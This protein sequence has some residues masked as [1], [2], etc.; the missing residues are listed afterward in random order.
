MSPARFFHLLVALAAL[1]GIVLS[2]A[3]GP[4]VPT[5][6][7]LRT[8]RFFSFFTISTNALVAWAAIGRALPPGRHWRAL[9]TRPSMRTAIA[10][11]ILVV[12][13]I[14]HLLLSDMVRP[15]LSG[16]LGNMLVH[17][18]APAGWLLCWFAFGP[19]GGIDARAPLRWM[20]YP[21]LYG[22]WTLAHGALLG[23]YPYPFMNVAS[24]GYPAVLRTMA[25]MALLFLAIAYALRWVDGR[26]A[27]R[28]A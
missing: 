16:W 12:A 14:F 20:A 1:A 8:L 4:P 21:L 24:H 17:Q 9:A 13:L 26:L 27:R 23:W 5:P 25:L 22:A 18:A 19:H 3:A 10:L 2:F 7:G 28:A 6:I 11:Y 15:G